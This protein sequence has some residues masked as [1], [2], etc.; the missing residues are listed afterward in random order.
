MLRQD[1]PNVSQLRAILD[2]YV[3]LAVVHGHL[4]KATGA[5]AFEDID[6]LEARDAT[7]KPLTQLARSSMPPAT[8]GTVSV[9]ERLFQQALGAT[10][11]GMKMFV[12]EGDVQACKKGE[13][14]V[15]FANET[16]TWETP[17]P[18][19]S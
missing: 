2:R 1:L 5:L 4:D 13:L 19:C 11:R 8:V 18:G 6:T 17:I 12:F 14:S 3:F 16:Y 15:P 7:G 9:I 10:G